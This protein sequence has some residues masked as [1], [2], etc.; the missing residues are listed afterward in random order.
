MSAIKHALAKLD[1]AVGTLEHSLTGLEENIAG[2]QRDMFTA[3]AN[4]NAGAS[5]GPV[6]NSALLAQKLDN[7]IGKVEEI[8]KESA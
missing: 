6:V 4:Q 1:G 5:N 8:L 2:Q 7:A 3:T